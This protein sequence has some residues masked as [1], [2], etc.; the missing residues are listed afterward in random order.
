MVKLFISEALVLV[1]AAHRYRKT[2]VEELNTL[3]MMN[4]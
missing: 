1:I 3:I 2:D 4:T